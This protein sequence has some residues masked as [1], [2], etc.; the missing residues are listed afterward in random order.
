[1][2]TP[3]A[4]ISQLNILIIGDSGTGKSSY[5][6]RL[7]QQAFSHDTTRTKECDILTIKLKTNQGADIS[8]K[9]FN[10]A[11]SQRGKTKINEY[12][13]NIDGCIIMFDLSRPETY[14]NVLGWHNDIR[15]VNKSD[16]LQW[17][18]LANKCD[19]EKSQESDY[20]IGSMKDYCQ[21]LG[22][23]CSF[24][25]SNKEN[26]NIEKSLKTLIDEIIKR[27]KPSISIPLENEKREYRFKVLVIGER[28]TGKTAIIN[29]YTKNTFS[30][31]YRTTIGA[32][33]AVQKIQYD[34]N[35]IVH[36]HIW[37]IAGEERFGGMTQLF[38]KD[39]AGCLIV[40][41]ITTPVSLTN[42]AAKWKDDFDKKL[43]IHENNQ[44]P[45]ILIGNKCDLKRD[46]TDINEDFINEF[47]RRHQFTDY[48]ATSAK[49]NINI[50]EAFSILLG[51][52][53]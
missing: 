6:K 38:Y 42:S 27:K 40:F 36:L 11:G 21:M 10:I 29:R 17:M 28:N 8:I 35:T 30:G 20:A 26:I 15:N 23:C 14:D 53:K 44:V 46:G 33:L 24:E 13:K 3:P 51:K 39:A 25:T 31:T 18:L 37:D 1:M 50:K 43:D 5:I 48:L 41:D 52:V 2:A 45:C 22:S 32:D 4:P 19:L 47:S 12:F 16:D 49:N 7:Q 9:I 34:P